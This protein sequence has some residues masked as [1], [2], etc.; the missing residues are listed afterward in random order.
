VRERLASGAAGLSPGD[1]DL[2]ATVAEIV[3]RAGELRP[4]EADLEGQRLTLELLGVKREIAAARAAGAGDL[5]RLVARREE[6]EARYDAAITRS[7]DETR[8]AIE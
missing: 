2:A 3:V 8:A 1:E 5:R 6:L 4:S 7:L